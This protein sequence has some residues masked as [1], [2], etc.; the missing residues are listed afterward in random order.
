[1]NLPQWPQ[2]RKFSKRF[3]FHLQMPLVRPAACQITAAAALSLSQLI[4]GASIHP[5]SINQSSLAP[6]IHSTR[7]HGQVTTSYAF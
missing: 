6:S 2:L 7:S 1:M 3:S 4:S 5:Q